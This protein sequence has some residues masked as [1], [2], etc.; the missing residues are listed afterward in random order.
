MLLTSKYLS[1]KS[2][3]EIYY[4]ESY[5]V[6]LIKLNEKCQWKDNCELRYVKYL[7]YFTLLNYSVDFFKTY[8]TTI[9]HEIQ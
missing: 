1:F 2:Q 5:V 9:E 4:K 8:S 6:K 3:I 7:H